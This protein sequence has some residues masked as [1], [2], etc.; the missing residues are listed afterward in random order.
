[1]LYTLDWDVMKEEFFLDGENRFHERTPF[2][3]VQEKRSFVSQLASDIIALAYNA[4][5]L[6]E[7]HP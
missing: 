4:T 6:G 2:S 5:F 3:K 7:I 1:M